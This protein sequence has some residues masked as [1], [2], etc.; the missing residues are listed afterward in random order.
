MIKYNFTAMKK[1]IVLTFSLSLLTLLSLSFMSGPANR[2]HDKTGSPLSNGT[3]MNCHSSGSYSPNLTVKVLDGENEVNSFNPGQSYTLRY[4]LLNTGSPLAFGFQT[5]ILDEN[6]ESAGIFG[7]I[8]NGFQLIDLG[9]VTY[10][11]HSQPAPL[12]SFEVEWTAPEDVDNPLTIYAG[13]VAA[14][15]NN[16]TGGDGAD[17]SSLV[18]SPNTSAVNLFAKGHS[19]MFSIEE[20]PIRDDLKL[21]LQPEIHQAELIIFSQNQHIYRE[22]LVSRHGGEIKS[23]NLSNLPQG[24]YFISIADKTGKQSEKFIKL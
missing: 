13:S 11:E 8:P 10:L 16:N 22:S 5:V 18:L 2:G 19:N 20:N 1:M 15:S 3:C 21:S 7:E 12:S 24:I 23:I 9:G 6:N 17:T 4:H 14:N